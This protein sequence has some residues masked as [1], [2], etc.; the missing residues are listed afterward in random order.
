MVPPHLAEAQ[1]ASEPEPP[2]TTTHPTTTGTEVPRTHRLGQSSD[3]PSF[4][5]ELIAGTVGGCLGITVVYPL[6]TVKSR[7]VLSCVG[8][9][10]RN[11]G[12]RGCVARGRTSPANA[13]TLDCSS[14]DHDCELLRESSCGALHTLVVR[15]TWLPLACNRSPLSVF[16]RLVLF[17]HVERRC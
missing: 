12:F 13:G 2:G 3:M 7:Q 1:S 5:E 6:D 15:N 11:L 8:C 16:A 9:E 10:H 4:G 17:L 14:L